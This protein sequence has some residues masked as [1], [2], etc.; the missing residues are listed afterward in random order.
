MI[1]LRLKGIDGV[2]FT[3]YA[4]GDTFRNDHNYIRFNNE[5]TRGYRSYPSSMLVEKIER[6][7]ETICAECGEII[8]LADSIEVDYI[9]LCGSCF[10]TAVENEEII[11]CHDCGDWTY[12]DNST[13][14]DGEDYRVCEGCR[15]NYC[16]CDRC[17]G[18][19]S[20]NDT[21]EV[22]TSEDYSETWCRHCTDDYAVWCERE[23]VY[24]ASGLAVEVHMDDGYD[25]Y[26]TREYARNHFYRCCHCNDWFESCGDLC[27]DSN[28]DWMCQSCAE[29]ENERLRRNLDSDMNSMPNRVV[30]PLSEDYVSVNRYHTNHGQEQFFGAKEG[31]IF[32]GLGIELE[33]CRKNGNTN[34]VLRGLK[35]I[36]GNHVTYETDCSIGDGFEMVSQ[37]HTIDEFYKVDWALALDYLR[38]NGF[39]SHDSE[40]C[41]LHVHL[42]RAL[43]GDTREQQ[44]E[45]IGKMILFYEKWYDN[46]VKISRRAD[47]Q[48]R[49]ARRYYS[50]YSLID[51]LDRF[52]VAEETKENVLKDVCKNWKK[53]SVDRYKCVNTNNSNTI[54][55]RIMRGT[56]RK[57]TFYATIDFIWNIA[58]NCKT[59]EDKELTK[60]DAWLKNMK[61]ET[62]EYI[63]SKIA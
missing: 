53:A 60:W 58:L 17:E 11:Q 14:I 50:D 57:E 48:L 26:F 56:L 9:H 1:E 28:D 4:M 13:Y 30:V 33:V 15:Q 40:K 51:F 43:F 52:G 37:P 18:Y 34:E 29:R 59:I 5:R 62:L 46:V 32:K 10:D 49:W 63:N 7:N 45:N 35:T 27:L 54:E 41:G 22:Y 23:D 31:E 6:P 3:E 55:I 12:Y 61:P 25:E 24:V 36:L 8:P 47:G 21:Y 2:E 38:T 39:I 20:P 42:S 16:W 44:D 19:Y